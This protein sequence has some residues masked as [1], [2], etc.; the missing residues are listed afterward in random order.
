MSEVDLWCLVE[1]C[2]K[3]EFWIAPSDAFLSRAVNFDRIHFRTGHPSGGR[4]YVELNHGDS[5]RVMRVDHSTGKRPSAVQY[6][7]LHYVSE[8]REEVFEFVH[9]ALH[10]AR[11]LCISEVDEQEVANWMKPTCLT[12]RHHSSVCADTEP[13]TGPLGLWQLAECVTSLRALARRYVTYRREFNEKLLVYIPAK[14]DETLACFGGQY[15][16][17]LHDSKV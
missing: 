3:S 15:C 1:V 4:Y 8:N 9:I 17:C 11:T 7:L 10:M 6:C 2:Q 14:D 5:H 12:H 16:A 13:F